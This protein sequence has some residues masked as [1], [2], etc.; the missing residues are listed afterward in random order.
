MTTSQTIAGMLQSGGFIITAGIVPPESADGAG[1]AKSVS[2][3][4]G[5]VHALVVSDCG[6]TRMAGIAAGAHLAQAGVDAVLE[7]STRDMNRIALQ[8]TLIGAASL[9]VSSV[10]CAP[11]VHQSLTE[12]KSAR[13]VFDLDPIQLMRMAQ[14]LNHGVKLTLG[15]STNPFSDPVE[16]QVIGLEKAVQSGAKFVITAPVFDMERFNEWMTI[17]RARKLQDRIHIIAG[18]LPLETKEDALEIREKFRGIS[19]P[20]KIIDKIGPGFAV[21]IVKELAEVD[22]VK[23]IHIH[24]TAEGMAEKLI[25]AAGVGS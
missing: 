2:S 16:L 18:V 1:F 5:K 8:S 20:D 24:P 17:I 7:L 6:G 12:T 21:D 15:A 14:R 9:G 25:D 10:I 4:A 22:G 11:G 3:L 23:G 19:I 13:G